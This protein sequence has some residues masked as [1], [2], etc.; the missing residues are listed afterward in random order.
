MARSEAAETAVEPSRYITIP[1]G[2]LAV[3]CF[4][5]GILPTYV[6]PVIDRVVTPI[7]R[8]SVV[9]ELVPPFF[10]FTH[11]RDA[12]L[13]DAFVSEFHD[14]GAQVG[15]QIVPGRGLVVLHQ[16]SERNPVIFAMSTSYSV[17][18]LALLLGASALVFRLLFRG[19]KVNRQPAWDGGL[20][21][22]L[23]EMTYTATGFSNH[24]RVIFDSIFRPS[25]AENTRESIAGHFRTAIRNGRQETY[26]VDRVAVQ[27]IFRGARW[28]AARVAGMHS[29]RVNAYAGYVLMSLLV[30]LVI[31]AL[32]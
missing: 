26:I 11:G 29:A 17:V 8:E 1:M 6:I 5:L 22:L 4:L 14:L 13:S 19:R 15:S 9:N 28:L 7:V 2:L 27:P 30:F 21:R 23:P 12:E 10:T 3:A 16:G 32:L 24:V 18:V 31:Q 25:M 20:R